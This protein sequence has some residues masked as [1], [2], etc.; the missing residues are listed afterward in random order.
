M[1]SPEERQHAARLLQIHKR[2]LEKLEEKKA[3]LAGELNLALDN[4]IAQEQADIEALR[5][6]ATPPPSKTI[7]E[8]VTSASGG[9]PGEIDLMMLFMQGTQ[10][11][12]RMT[13]AEQD[14]KEH[15]EKQAEQTT[16][17][18]DQQARDALW[19]M[20]TKQVVDELV[21]QVAASEKERKKNAPFI[22]RVLVIALTLGILAL[23][24]SCSA[25]IIAA[26]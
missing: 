19:R 17:I 21:V 11:N 14:A 15:R 13:Q 25:L 12:S 3:L 4:Q 7:Q 23:M 1:A 6:L 5:P 2:N 22:R 18:I 26:R 9:P 16:Q 10:I 24:V 20:Q 8:L